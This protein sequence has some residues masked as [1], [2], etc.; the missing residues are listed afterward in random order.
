MIKVEEAINTILSSTSTLKTEVVDIMEALNRVLG[1][2]IYSKENI[3]P[4]NNSAMD[5]YAV[6]SSCF[7]SF[8]EESGVL[9]NIEGNIP[10]GYEL[11]VS[12]CKETA[13]RIMTGAKVPEGYDTVIPIEHTKSN[14]NK[15]MI[16]KKARRWENVR[17]QGEDIKEGDLVL[18]KG[19]L[20]NPTKIGM[21]AALNIKYVK[22]AVKPKV[23]ILA[24]GDELINLGEEL[25]PGKIRNINSYS[26]QSML[27]DAGCNVEDLGIAKDNRYEITNKLK[28][29]KECDILIISGGVS[30]GDYDYTKIT[31]KEM[32]AEEKFWKIAVKPGKPVLFSLLVNTLVFGLPGNPASTVVAFQEFVLP[33]IYKLQ[34]RI[35]KQ[36]NMVT[37]VLE[38]SIK[39]KPGKVHFLSGKCFLKEGRL[40]VKAMKKQS[41]GSFS[42][43]IN[44]N[45]FIVVPEEVTEIKKGEEVLIQ[46]T[47]EI[48]E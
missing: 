43:I 25:L 40:Y 33:S 3:P 2:D 34:G 18:K 44:S 35:N 32:G 4:F 24:T 11:K 37:A 5:G 19:E 8:D 38:E 41:S 29:A 17:F 45:C 12:P 26:L 23:A 46:I 27:I 47:N 1:E 7:D 22:V 28:R 48:G 14:N 39:K 36:L 15:V 10:A 21:L 9:L 42:S 30:V 20:I 31:L 13:I 6:I 16:L